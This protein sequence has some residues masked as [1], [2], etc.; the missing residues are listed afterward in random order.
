MQP[1]V[2]GQFKDPVSIHVKIS[3]TYQEVI[4]GYV[5]VAGVW[6]PFYT[7]L[8]LD[9]LNDF[10]NP[11]QVT[12]VQIGLGNVDNVDFITP[13]ETNAQVIQTLTSAGLI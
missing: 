13:A 1:K 4:E 8:L 3:G 7:G 6:R 2:G 12:K 5:K 9:H 10:N 11:H